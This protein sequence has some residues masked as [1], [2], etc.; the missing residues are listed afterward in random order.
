LNSIAAFIIMFPPPQ[1]SA[2]SHEKVSFMSLGSI[3]RGALVK[4]NGRGP[5]PVLIVSH[6]TGESKENYIELAAYLANQGISSLLLDMHGHGESGGQRL[7]V[8]MK[9]WK[10]DIVAAMHYLKTRDDVD[11]ER[12]AGFGLSSGGTA[13]L[14]TALDDNR[15]KTL[16]TLGATVKNTL[17]WNIRILM[18]CGSVV[19]Y[20][21]RWLTGEDLRISILSLLDQVALASD[22]EINAR[23]MRDPGKIA[24][25]EN[26][27]LPGASEAFSV[28]TIHRVH[29]IKIPNL[30]IWGEDDQL[31]PTSTAHALFHA[32]TCQKTLEIIPGNGHVGHLDR[33]RE[34]VFEL[35]AQ[36]LLK[37]LT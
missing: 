36:W 2:E 5:L 12:V 28:D 7:H 19:G 9:E 4:G 10:A 21:K 8:K 23:L 20:L 15:L 29:R 30:V 26:F 33:H 6:G 3:I 18:R 37:H 22:P 27:P 16:I 25:L 11:M 32:L 14:E 24:S 35:T 17:P 31:D 34:R 1:D 13:M